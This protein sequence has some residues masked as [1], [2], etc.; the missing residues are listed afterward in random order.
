MATD[1]LTIQGGSVR[2]GQVFSMARDKIPYLSSGLKSSTIQ[3]SITV[4][5]YE[6]E[7]LPTELARHDIELE[8]EKVPEMAPVE[9]YHYLCNRKEESI[10]NDNG[11]IPNDNDSHKKETK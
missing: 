9:G 11:C 1:I 2:V 7:E 5:S 10:E 4:N 3:S 8:A 6:H